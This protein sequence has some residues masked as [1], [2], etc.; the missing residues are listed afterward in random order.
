VRDG[1][2]AISDTSSSVPLTYRRG[3]PLAP[4]AAGF[5]ELKHHGERGAL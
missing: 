1:S 2:F 5:A 4:F 3:D